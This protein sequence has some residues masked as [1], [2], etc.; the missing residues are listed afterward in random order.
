[1]RFV[2]IVCLWLFVA[3]AGPEPAP[4]VGPV[5]STFEDDTLSFEYPSNWQVI[6]AQ[7]GADPALVI[8]STE[9]APATEPPLV[10]LGLDGV[11]LAWRTLTVAPTTT[12]DPSFSSEVTVGGRSATASQQVA[13]G[14]CAAIQGDELLTV[15]VES[16]GSAQDVEMIACVRGPN[17]ELTGAAIAGMLASVH[18]KN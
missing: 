7:S 11:Y 16:P 2:V 12:P 18:W 4:S 3:C 13:D 10:M 8:L 9:P 14:E 17:L 1:M 15:V 5:V 6:A